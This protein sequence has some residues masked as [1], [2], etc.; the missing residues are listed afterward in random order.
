M[1]NIANNID[2]GLILIIHP[3]CQKLSMYVFYYNYILFNSVHLL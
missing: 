2:G 1:F 3:V